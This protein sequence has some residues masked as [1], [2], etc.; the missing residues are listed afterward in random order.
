MPVRLE[1]PK[2]E[3]NE[4]NYFYIMYWEFEYS[5][6]EIS[7]IIGWSRP[8]V[9]N[10]MIEYNIPR[11]T[12]SETLEGKYAGKKHPM[13]GKSHDDE[14]IRKI[15]ESMRGEKGPFY[16]KEHNEE[17]KNKMSEKMMG[18]KNPMY[19]KDFSAEHRRKLSEALSGR[20][21]DEEH[22]DKIS[23]AMRG[24]KNPFYNVTG[25]DHPRH[26]DKLSHEAKARMSRKMSGENN[27]FFGKTGEEHPTWKGGYNGYNTKVWEEQREKVLERDDYECQECHIT[28]EEHKK[29][30]GC[31]LHV[32]HIIPY[33]L[34]ESHDL[35]NLITLCRIHHKEAEG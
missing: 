7:D 22:K 27:P 10:R 19:N 18:G 24:E 31:E 33:R 12:P 32:H 35:D 1:V 17:Y 3:T 9:R 6:Q 14:T 26:N 13:Y 28:N 30:H 29:K 11:R 21:F 16:G 5:I 15:S 25:E 20:E 34:C 2:W 23:Q 8:T 4:E